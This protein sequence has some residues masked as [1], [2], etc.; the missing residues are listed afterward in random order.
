MTWHY[1]KNGVKFGP[2]TSTEL[3]RLASSGNLAPSDLVWKDG[4]NEWRPAI[5][6]QGLFEGKASK[7][8]ASSTQI[9][10]GVADAVNAKG[11]RP[12]GTISDMADR[13]SDATGVEKLDGFSLSEMF[14]E[15]FSRHS[16]DDVERYSP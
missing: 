9:P 13:L 7:G 16:P 14:S 15:T 1:A 6:V 2:V 4:M 12:T 8:H 5:D 11:L 10:R 3:K